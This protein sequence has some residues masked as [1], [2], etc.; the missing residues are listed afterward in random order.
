MKCKVIG[1]FLE[2]GQYQKK[3]GTMLNYIKILS[4]SDSIQINNCLVEQDIKRLQQIEVDCE[5]KSSQYGLMISAI[6]NK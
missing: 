3:D 6:N 1:E 5:V 2:K 4:G